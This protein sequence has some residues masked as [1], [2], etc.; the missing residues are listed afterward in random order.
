MSLRSDLRA[1]IRATSILGG[2][3]FVGC[4]AAYRWLSPVDSAVL[5]FASVWNL[6]GRLLLVRRLKTVCR[7]TP[8]SHWMISQGKSWRLH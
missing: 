5:A 8:G 2:L 1:G 6:A 7:K 4:L 3:S